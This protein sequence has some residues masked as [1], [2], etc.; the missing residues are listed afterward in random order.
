MSFRI[1]VG[2][3]SYQAT[4][5]ELEDLFN[6][7]DAKVEN[8]KIITDFNTGRS[9]GFAFIEVATL[10]DIQKEIQRLNGFLFKGRRLVV[11]EAKPKA[12]KGSPLNHTLAKSQAA[13]SQE[14][15]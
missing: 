13:G 4:E 8:A 3:L 6:A 10:E 11:C 5:K 1:Y 7:A 15:H 12:S 14:E 9:R 2:N